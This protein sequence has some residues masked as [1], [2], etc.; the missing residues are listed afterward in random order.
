[1]SYGSTEV[2]ATAFAITTVNVPDRLDLRDMDDR[3][4]L[5]DDTRQRRFDLSAFRAWAPRLFF[6]AV[7]AVIVFVLLEALETWRTALSAQQLSQRLSSALGVPVQI[8]T[9]QFAINPSPRLLLTKVSVDHN[10]VLSDI[11]INV[12]TR[13]IAQVFQGHGWNWG[14]AIVGPTSLTLEQCRTLL[15]LLPKLN[16]ALPKSL[17]NFRFDRLTI[18]DQPWLTGPWQI[19]MSREGGAGFASVSAEQRNGSGLL[20][21]DVK[22]TADPAVVGF[23]MEGRNWTLPFGPSFPIE[24]AVATG[25]ASSAHVELSEFSLGG[26]FGA[27]KGSLSAGLEAAAWSLTGYVEAEGLDLA[28]LVRQLAPSPASP[29][30]AN[31]DSSTLLQGNASFTGKFEGKGATL[32]EAAGAAV[33]LAPVEVRWPV[34][35]GINLGFAATRPGST[36]GTSGGTTRFSSLS[37]VVVAGGDGISFRDIRAHAGALAASGQV[38]MSADHSLSGLLHVDLGSTR[39][40][41][42]IR[43]AVRGTLAHPQFGR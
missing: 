24:E 14:E 20:R 2:P 15:N 21:F 9:S 4:Q 23:Q 8:E 26:P 32:T 16:S 7:L 41:A 1:M 5:E 37:A 35:N 22:P 10:L 43:V 17:S 13:H 30:D 19:D 18:A 29:D 33:F 11:S 28:A 3:K 12:G 25:Q 39:V 40:L 6:I 36:G 34:L 38:N 31:Q 42:P 27:V